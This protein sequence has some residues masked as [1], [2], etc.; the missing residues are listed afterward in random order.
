MTRRA[1]LEMPIFL[2]NSEAILLRHWCD[3]PQS[4]G[5]REKSNEAC[6]ETRGKEDVFETSW[7][8]LR[9]VEYRAL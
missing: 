8:K 1:Y 3:A 9:T 4:T 6:P 7:R 5:R 2:M